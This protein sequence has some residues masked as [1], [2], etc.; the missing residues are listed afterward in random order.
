[1]GWDV[2]VIPEAVIVYFVR[3]STCGLNIEAPSEAEAENLRSAHWKA[4]DDRWDGIDLGLDLN[5][6]YEGTFR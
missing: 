2:R 1:M 3:C 4:H 5:P 6:D